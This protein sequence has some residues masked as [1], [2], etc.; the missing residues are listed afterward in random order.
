MGILLL[1]ALITWIRV[2]VI[3]ALYALITWIRIMLPY[4]KIVTLRASTRVHLA[5]ADTL[6]LKEDA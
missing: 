5:L 6:N 3:A 4:R 2:S 1:Y